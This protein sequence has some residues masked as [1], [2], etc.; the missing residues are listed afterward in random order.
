MSPK[1]QRAATGWLLPLALLLLS[2]LILK[3][4]WAKWRNKERLKMRSECPDF[5]TSAADRN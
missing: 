4:A 1:L 2:P 3:A 5:I